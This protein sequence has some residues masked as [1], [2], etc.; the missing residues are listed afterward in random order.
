MKIINDNQVERFKIIKE[1]RASFLKLKYSFEVSKPSIVELTEKL[2]KEDL[3]NEEYML[4]EKKYEEDIKKLSEKQDAFLGEFLRYIEF[5]ETALRMYRS[6]FIE[7][8]TQFAFGYTE[9]REREDEQLRLKIE[10]H[11]KN[12]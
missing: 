3:Y 4:K 9:I 6:D 1:Q 7:Y 11:K 12:M 10:E 2:N 5:H 8:Y